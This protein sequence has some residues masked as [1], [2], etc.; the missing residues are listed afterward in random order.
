MPNVFMKCATSLRYA[1]RVRALFRL[2][3]HTSSS[4]IAAN[5]STLTRTDALCRDTT[6]ARVFF[7]LTSSCLLLDSSPCFVALFFPCFFAIC[8]SY[9]VRDNPVYHVLLYHPFPAAKSR[10]MHTCFLVRPSRT[11]V[12]RNT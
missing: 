11:G 1:R 12:L 4:G 5:A 2:A 3:S 8:G 7:S 9:L 6:S 10:V